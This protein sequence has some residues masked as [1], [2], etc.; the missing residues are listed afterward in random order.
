MRH[1]SLARTRGARGDVHVV[2]D[3]GLEAGVDGDDTTGCMKA[4]GRERENAR[5]REDGKKRSQ[6]G[7][8]N[9]TR[10]HGGRVAGLQ[11]A[12]LTSARDVV[13]TFSAL[14]YVLCARRL[15]PLSQLGS[16]PCA[17]W[18]PRLGGLD[19]Y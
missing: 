11:V 6:L 17:R 19:G 16:F 4:T 5:R 7:G 9:S 14:C 8:K 13:R 15:L 12:R 3:E 10:W 2:G 18:R 1:R